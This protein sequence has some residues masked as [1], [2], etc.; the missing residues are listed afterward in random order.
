[1]D[2]S[3]RLPYV[4]IAIAGLLSLA[5]VIAFYAREGQRDAI[6]ALSEIEIGFVAIAFSLGIYAVE[7]LFSVYLEG[8]RLRPGRVR[9]RLTGPLSV[10]IIVFSI[11]LFALA[12]GLGFGL[13]TDWT[14]KGLGIVAGIGCL[15]LSVLLVFYKEAFVGSEA[16]FDDR[17][18]GVPW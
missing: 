9:P 6:F 16:K 10:A 12:L 14:R 3:P 17:E 2:N 7:G 11:A 5:A 13:V 4:S 8:R 18:D 1:M 15:V